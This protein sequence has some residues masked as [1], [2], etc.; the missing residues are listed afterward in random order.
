M[1][2][3]G[4]QAL[5]EGVMMKGDKYISTAVYNPS[6]NLVVNKEEFVPISKK[7]PMLK[8]PILRGFVSLIEMMVIGMKTLVYSINIASEEHEK[9]SKN[10]LS[11]SIVISL[12]VS[13]GIF[14]IIPAIF[15]NYLRIHFASVN[16]LLLNAIEGCIRISIFLGFLGSTLLMKDMVRVYQFHGAEHKAVNAFEAGEKLT[17]E[18]VKKYSRIHIRCGTSF[19]VFVLITSIFV[20]SLIGRQDLLHRI[21]FKLLL[22]P[23][24][25][26]IAYELIRLAAKFHS[27]IFCKMLIT[28][29]LL[30]QRMTTKEP[31]EMQITAAIS[32]LKEVI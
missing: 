11:S 17:V 14:I 15:F 28:P 10:E 12:M 21:F 18:N 8:L 16:I 31:D 24:I 6:H 30:V 3:V 32:A 5:I 7:Y 27:N 23:L 22:F 20:F 2:Y 25:S 13:I 26:G 4:G 29:G 19:I 1:G 9:I